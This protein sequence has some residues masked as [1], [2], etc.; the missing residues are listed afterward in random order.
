MKAPIS[1][2]PAL[3]PAAGMMCGIVVQHYSHSC[4]WPLAAAALAAVLFFRSLHIPAFA[5]AGLCSG[6]IIASFAGAQT[7]PADAECENTAVLGIVHEVHQGRASISY[8]ILVDMTGP[9]SLRSCKP[10]LA[11]ATVSGFDTNISKGDTITAR[12]SLLQLPRRHYMPAVSETDEYLLSKGIT[13]HLLQ[14]E[15]IARKASHDKGQNLRDRL[16][17]ALLGSAMSEQSAAIVCAIVLG[18]SSALD[19]ELLESYRGAGLAHILALSGLHV[20]I[21]L[22]LTGIVLMPLRL[23]GLRAAYPVCAVILLWLYVLFTGMPASV[24]RAA[25]MATLMI[26][27]GLLGRRYSP[28]NALAIAAML[29][30]AFSPSAL[31]E[32]GFQ[33][34][35]AAVLSIML[36]ALRLNPWAESRK[37]LAAATGYALSVPVAATLGTFPVA[38]Y[39][40]EMFPVYFLFANLLFCWILPWLMAASALHVILL[41]CGIDWSFTAYAVD[42]I[43]RAMNT[44]AGYMASLPAA[45][46]AIARH[47]AC[48]LIVAVIC[49]APALLLSLRRR[50]IF[51]AAATG[52]LGAAAV[53]IVSIS[54]K[55]TDHT[56]IYVTDSQSSPQLMIYSPEGA[57]LFAPTDA[58]ISQRHTA[59]ARSRGY[60]SVNVKNGN[61]ITVGDKTFF[62]ADYKHR[63]RAGKTD[64]MLVG[65]SYAA[66]PGHA[67]RMLKP[68]TV[69]LS[70]MADADRRRKWIKACEQMQ[71]PVADLRERGVHLILRN[72]ALSGT[73]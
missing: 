13:A 68:D 35:F 19:P 44:S 42:A 26:A 59:C 62:I 24:V 30:L 18:D 15:I 25:V 11:S 28:V 9:D 64:Y 50:R 21:L 56:E 67:L 39:W 63:L 73:R 54:G 57:T 10:F 41:A 40:F 2:L 8:T 60:D 34:S 17:S 23:S 51:P 69:V 43:C 58:G 22:M 16:A 38:A 46:P 61:E 36:F 66:D 52:L 72:K 33:L 45:T 53:A 37:K 4:I 27:A 20:G 12:C 29:I 3:P 14:P 32:A 49:F 71:I 65:G 55:I 6:W 48:A 31:F 70:V 7:P 1:L 47:T 5:L